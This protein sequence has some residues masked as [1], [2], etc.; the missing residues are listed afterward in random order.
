MDP[1]ANIIRSVIDAY[2]LP[3]GI[4]RDYAINAQLNNPESRR[5]L[6]AWLKAH[7]KIADSSPLFSDLQNRLVTP[8]SI[9]SKLLHVPF[10]LVSKAFHYVVSSNLE[11]TDIEQALISKD[12]GK[13]KEY[14]GKYPEEIITHADLIKAHLEI[15]TIS[16][17]DFIPILSSAAENLK[18]MDEPIRHYPFTET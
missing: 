8:I 4:E 11:A 16:L 2:K 12:L 5:L 17:S 3:A 15:A 7:P 9:T 13:L 1:S 10:S 18:D 6:D 14:F